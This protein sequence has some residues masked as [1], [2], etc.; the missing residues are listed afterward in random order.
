MR[1]SNKCD[2]QEKK[3]HP[4]TNRQTLA[5][6]VEGV[7]LTFLIVAAAVNVGVERTA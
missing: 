6:E 3:A 4:Q 7:F 2:V 5:Y 1:L